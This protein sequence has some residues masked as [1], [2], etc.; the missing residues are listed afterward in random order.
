MRGEE[1]DRKDMKRKGAQIVKIG[2]LKMVRWRDWVALPARVWSVFAPPS[3]LLS[4][5]LSHTGSYLMCG[6]GRCVDMCVCPYLKTSGSGPIISWE[7]VG[8]SGLDQDLRWR[9]E[10]EL[11]ALGR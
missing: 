8:I 2:E 10:G 5:T 9:N 3:L 1:I 4:S 7:M 6:C 11:I